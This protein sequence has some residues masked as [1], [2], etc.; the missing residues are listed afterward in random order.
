MI[1]EKMMKQNDLTEALE[2]YSNLRI[3]E[4]DYETRPNESSYN[5]FRDNVKE[6]VPKLRR[7]LPPA[8]FL[9]LKLGELEAKLEATGYATAIPVD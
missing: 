4:A 2:V 9:H 8:V 6:K 5:R 1:G 3:L 7:L